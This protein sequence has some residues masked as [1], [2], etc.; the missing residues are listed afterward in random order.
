MMKPKKNFTN[1]T[2]SADFTGKSKKSPKISKSEDSNSSY[3]E[4]S[5]K[6]R[7]KPKTG[8]SDDPRP[9][10]RVRLGKSEKPAGT[11]RPVN[12]GKV[13]FYTPTT[14]KG[15]QSKSEEAQLAEGTVQRIALEILNTFEEAHDRIDHLLQQGIHKNIKLL[16]AREKGNLSKTVLNVIRWKLK[17]DYIISKSLKR[18]AESLDMTLKN[19]YRLATFNVV[20][21]NKS[22]EKA[23]SLSDFAIPK[24]FGKHKETVRDYIKFLNKAKKDI[25][26]PNPK[27]N[28][29]N[30]LSITYSHP[31][32]LVEKWITNYG[33][34]AVTKLCE[35]NNAEPALTLRLNSIKAT[36]KDVM[37]NLERDGFQVSAC[38]YAENGL[39]VTGRGEI[40]ST[41]S[42]KDGAFEIQD[43]SSQLFAAW[44]DP[45]PNHTVIDACAG[46]GGKSLYFST[47][48]N[49][50]GKILATD[51]NPRSLEKLRKRST[52]S[53]STNIE[54]VDLHTAE[55]AEL[56]TGKADKVVIDAPCSG[57]GVLA[58][59]PDIKWR[60]DPESFSTLAAEQL[61]LLNY[62]ARFVK[63]GGE[64][65][66]GT[67][68]LNPDENENIIRHFLATDT[69]FQMKADQHERF[70]PFIDNNGFFYIKPFEHR[71][72]GFF[73]CK[74]IRK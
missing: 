58:R 48:M 35:F 12:R 4:K 68:T 67:C 22:A 24:E 29:V 52:R 65:I 63:D 60:F 16:E 2:K 56:W 15:A 11:P 19:S 3:G 33:E 53:G 37:A 51:T 23:V 28:L 66:Y 62:F 40:F 49:N 26:Y 25:P 55:T 14:F 34:E 18:D 74:L 54:I 46:A 30:A 41:Q 21:M 27:K 7:W 8:K 47:A 44:C 20:W 50:K 1:S 5:G 32:W 10:F 73:G 6:A 43:E 70:I 13:N 17:I 36:K 64:M 57:L 31:V 39:H 69:R 9:S 59:N 72:S 42:F 45:Q 38:R 71:L 61:T